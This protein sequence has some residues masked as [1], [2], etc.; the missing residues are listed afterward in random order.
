MDAIAAIR[1]LPAQKAEG[2]ELL[3]AVLNAALNGEWGS[4]EPGM[5]LRR[6]VEAIR[7]HRARTALASN[8]EAK[9][10]REAC[11]GI[12]DDYITSDTHHPNYVLIP[13]VKFKAIC[14]ALGDKPDAG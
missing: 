8:G 9:R 12:A 2:E 6:F 10:L 4:Y 3:A 14:T 13:T 1:A 11:E 5:P 7:E